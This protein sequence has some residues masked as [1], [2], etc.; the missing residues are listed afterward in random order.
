MNKPIL[1]VSWETGETHEWV[2]KY[3]F[4]NAIAKKMFQE[5]QTIL[6]Q[7]M[8]NLLIVYG[9]KEIMV[10]PGKKLYILIRS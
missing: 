8:A 9:C 10:L 4:P 2:L 1:G 5:S 3:I 6:E 7:M